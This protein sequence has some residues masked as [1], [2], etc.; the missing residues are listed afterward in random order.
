[1]A[2]AW[3]PEDQVHHGWRSRRSFI[4]LLSPVKLVKSDPRWLLEV[5][6]LTVKD[7]EA[8]NNISSL[9]LHLN[10]IIFIDFASPRFDLP[11]WI[12]WPDVF[13]PGKAKKT[14]CHSFQPSLLMN[15]GWLWLWLSWWS[16]ALVDLV[17]N[18]VKNNESYQL[19]SITCFSW[20]LP[21]CQ[22]KII[23]IISY[24]L[25]GSMNGKHAKYDIIHILFTII[26]MVHL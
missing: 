10:N 24:L 14:P 13:H 21:R 6:K 20:W 15:Y 1:M 23:A 9:I 5:T 12:K 11:L 19:S 25:L 7:R 8:I 16:S 4:R 17:I 26:W 18:D 3:S 22:S 2:V